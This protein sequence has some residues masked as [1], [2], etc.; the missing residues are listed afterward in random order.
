MPLTVFTAEV[1]DLSN[2]SSKQ[3]PLQYGSDFII[4]FFTGKYMKMEKDYVC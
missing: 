2:S 4:F 3:C 1:Y